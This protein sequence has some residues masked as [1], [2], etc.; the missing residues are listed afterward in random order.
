MTSRSS[1]P[2]PNGQDE[3]PELSPTNPFYNE[4]GRTPRMQLKFDDDQ[5]PGG[6]PKGYS[7]ISDAFARH[8]PSTVVTTPLI[9][10]T[11]SKFDGSDDP[12]KFLSDFV[13]LMQLQGIDGTHISDSAKLL[14]SFS[15]HLKGPAFMWYQNLPTDPYH[16]SWTALRE[17]FHEHFVSMNLQTNSSI[18]AESVAF[19]NLSLGTKTLDEFHCI[20]VQKG[21]KLHKTNLD[22]MCKFI[23]GLP[24]SLQYFV[25]AG[26]P[27]T[28]DD[29]LQSAKMGEAVGYRDDVAPPFINAVKTPTVTSDNSK[30]EIQ[31]QA[32]TQKLDTLASTVHQQNIQKEHATTKAD[33]TTVTCYLCGGKGHMKPACNWAGNKDPQSTTCCQICVQNGHSAEDC[34]RFVPISE[35]RQARGVGRGRP[36]KRR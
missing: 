17:K 36:Q 10:I 5:S 26:R 32:L 8:T 28:I 18:Y 13:A 34:A 31:I 12:E 14:A 2:E 1:T 33:P 11:L 15:L 35:N 19:D 21:K 4:Q 9:P 16:L 23:D 25:R 6:I 24:K 7:V 29:A 22:T 20:V 30:L 3:L 27:N